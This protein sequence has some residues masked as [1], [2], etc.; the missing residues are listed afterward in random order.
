MSNGIKILIFALILTVVFT[1]CIAVGLYIKNNDASESSE[2]GT[3]NVPVITPEVSEPELL[4]P[5]EELDSYSIAVDIILSNSDKFKTAFADRISAEFIDKAAGLFGNE[6]VEKLADA[7]CESDIDSEVL[8]NISGYSEKAFITLLDGCDERT[9]VWEDNGDGITELSFVGDVSFADTSSVMRR[10]KE[11]AKGVDGIV[12]QGVLDIMRSVDIT[13]ANNE[14]TFT[15]RGAPIEGKRYTFR[16]NPENV[17]IYHEM[18]VDIVGMANNHAFDYGEFSLADTLVTLDGA[19]IA[20]V[21]AGL[22]LNDAKEPYYYIINGRKIAIIAASAVDYVYT[23]I[24]TDSQSGVFQ[25]VDPNPCLELIKEAKESSD[26]VIVY[27]HWGI[28]S[29]TNLSDYQLDMGKAF[30]DAGADAVIGMHSHCMQ[31]VEM[32]N[33]KF[34]AYSLG[35]FTFSSYTLS[36]AMAVITV[37]GTG[38]LGFKLYPMMQ[39]NNMT[40]ICESEEL[41]KQLSLL[42]SL[43]I[44]ADVADDFTVTQK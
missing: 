6:F 12:A 17:S 39:R 33:G 38:E 24:A 14:F 4:L 35:N 29:T 18:G 21:G 28:E 20:H 16:A 32:Y 43:A 7:V 34:I 9:A 1:V 26:Y 15:E 30:A 5:P 23:R 13:M 41:V 2:A 36:C 44:N 11:R 10:Y 27:V 37:D 22:D 8:Y 3:D 25:L 42:R 19:G 31:G 40:Y